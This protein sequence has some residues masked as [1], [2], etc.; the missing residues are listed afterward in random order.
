[1][2]IKENPEGGGLGIRDGDGVRG[3]NK[4][5]NHPSQPTKCISEYHDLFVT[6]GS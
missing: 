1:M 4:K 5:S 6:G 3:R 2:W